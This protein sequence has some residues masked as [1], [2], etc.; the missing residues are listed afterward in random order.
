MRAMLSAKCQHPRQVCEASGAD[1]CE[2][3]AV[4]AEDHAGKKGLEAAGRPP[5][6]T[7]DFNLH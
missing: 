2:Q 3:R 7:C 4:D 1:L 6:Q 5:P